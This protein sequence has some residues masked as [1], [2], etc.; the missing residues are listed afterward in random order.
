MSMTA[1]SPCQPSAPYLH[2]TWLKSVKSHD[3]STAQSL[4]MGGA[5]SSPLNANR[6]PHGLASAVGMA[7]G[8][9]VGDGALDPDPR[10][11]KRRRLSS[12]A[13]DDDV[14]R[15]SAWSSLRIDVLKLLHKDSKK[16]KSS[17]AALTQP[18][19]SVITKGCCRIT[20]FDVS[21][22]TPRLL[23]CQSQLCNLLTAKNPVGP[24]HLA[25]I[26]LHSPFHVPR[27]SLLINRLDDGRFDLSDSYQLLV[28]LEAAMGSPWP[29]LEP[30]DLGI[31]SLA[32][33]QASPASLKNWLLSSRF[34]SV[35]GRLR[36][37]LQLSSTAP[38][39]ALNHQTSY[40]MDVDLR[41]ASGFNS[42]RPH[43]EDPKSCITAL[44]PDEVSRG[45]A[46][47]AQPRL[48][49]GIDLATEGFT[50]GEASHIHDDDSVGDHTPSRSLR[51][52]EKPTV[53]NLKQ[54][55]DQ[56]QGRDHRR[57]ARSASVVANDGRIQYLLPP[58][59]PISLDC[60]R[61][62]TCGVYHES[63][64]QLQLHLQ[65]MHSSFDYVLETTGQGPQFRISVIRDLLTTPNK[66]LQ[67]SRS[68]KPFNLYSTA[69]S[70]QPWITSRYIVDAEYPPQSPS[71]K[72]RS[73][74]PRSTSPTAKGAKPAGLRRGP[75]LKSRKIAVPS[76]PQPLFHPISKAR[77]A[78]GQEV[79]E[80]VP[81]DEWLIHKHRECIGDFSDVTGAE[82][83]FIWEWD[84]YILRRNITSGAYFPRVWLS[85]VRDKSAWLVAEEQRMLE[86]G[87]HVSVLLAR[88]ALDEASLKRAL[89]YINSAREELRRLPQA[90][91]AGTGSQGNLSAPKLSPRSA[92]IRKSTNGLHATPLPLNLHLHQGH[93]ARHSISLAL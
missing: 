17:Q 49:N 58:E 74:Q 42:L 33:Q 18:R 71:A 5:L 31:S 54:L 35:F 40:V 47:M 43:D 24:H 20:I 39:D 30:L 64:S 92:Q 2:R 3:D 63:M 90:R 25:R 60:Y 75:K 56:A 82:K 68:I 1:Q 48:A 73:E 28:E 16:V 61:C 84:D 79:P 13:I 67:L 41:W 57:R 66:A 50:N 69:T 11:V 91:A 53:Y 51:A 70:D 37:P 93:D 14:S 44:D 83:E 23:H 8:I 81:D 86:F 46:L 72:A 29:P 87:K 19:G 88:D 12:A 27:D 21:S 55:S 45:T 7:M 89:S 34:D 6:Q 32:I 76:I 4:V 62:I 26:D 65:T 59:Q 77:L 52:R 10:P 80:V 78:P 22:G 85:F 15:P 9:G 38:S 36:N